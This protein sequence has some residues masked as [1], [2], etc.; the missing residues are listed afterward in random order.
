[1]AA[2]G[3]PPG[4]TLRFA[5]KPKK[6]RPG[7]TGP[8]SLHIANRNPHFGGG[9]WLAPPI[10]SG[11]TRL[12]GAP[13]RLP[14][15]EP[16]AVA[17][18]NYLSTQASSPT[19]R[20]Y[21][22]GDAGIQH[23][24]AAR[25]AAAYGIETAIFTPHPGPKGANTQKAMI[26]INHYF[27]NDYIFFLHYFHTLKRGLTTALAGRKNHP[28]GTPYCV[29]FYLSVAVLSQQN[30][31]SATENQAD[32]QWSCFV[33]GRESIC[34]RESLAIDRFRLPLP[35]RVGSETPRSDRARQRYWP[36]NWR[37][38]RG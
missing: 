5:K 19:W 27:S 37:K 31:P 6:N 29:I 32:A 14:V 25:A 11:P 7:S 22:R 13:F 4:A 30:P 15:H 33:N 9:F 3:R 16:G 21:P 10:N 36:G 1:M 8:A 2:P 38:I 23:S 17:S 35:V 18:L 12:S 28:P 26:S 34:A 24:R 20:N